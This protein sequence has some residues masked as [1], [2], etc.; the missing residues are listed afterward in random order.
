MSCHA[1][2]EFVNRGFAG[3]LWACC[4]CATTFEL[5]QLCSECAM[6]C[7]D[8]PGISHAGTSMKRECVFVTHMASTNNWMTR[9]CL[10]VKARS[11][12]QQMSRLKLTDT[13][14]AVLLQIPVQ[15]PAPFQSRIF[16]AQ[17]I[18][19]LRLRGVSGIRSVFL[20]MS[21]EQHSTSSIHSMSRRGT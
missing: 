15:S 21:A 9:V 4:V 19:L 1:H 3:F 17:C 8:A 14:K 20:T 6:C 7:C 11:T 5:A 2:I 13:F 18:Q 10:C 12:V 16:I